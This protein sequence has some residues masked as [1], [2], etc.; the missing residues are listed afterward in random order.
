MVK[1]E[2]WKDIIHHTF[3]E[4]YRQFQEYILSMPIEGSRGM[5]GFLLSKKQDPTQRLKEF[6]SWP[7]AFQAGTF[8]MWLSTF[9]RNT[10]LSS[11]SSDRLMELILVWFEKVKESAGAY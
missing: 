6:E 1:S 3:K 9:E 4:D 5:L 8:Y 10:G 11:A 2:Y 7:E